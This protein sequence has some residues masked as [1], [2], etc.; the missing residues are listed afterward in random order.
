MKLAVTQEPEER[1]IFRWSVAAAL[2]L[3]LLVFIGLTLASQRE[4]D[5]KFKPLASMDF[6]PYDPE[7][8]EPGGGSEGEAPEIVPEAEPAFE[9]VPEEPE[10]LPEIIESVSEE[11]APAPPPPP[12]E[13]P[14]PK[15]KPKE[16]PRPAAAPAAGRTGD[17]PAASQGLAGGRGIG[18]GQGGAGGGT[19]QGT[20]NALQAYSSQIRRRLER[21]K[22]YP[23]AAQSKRITGVATISFTVH[24]NGSVS[25][26]R[27]VRSSGQNILDDEVLALL[28]RVA[29]LPPIPPEVTQNSVTLTVPISFSVR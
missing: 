16:K 8:G 24:R 21:N 3:H 15:P 25:G 5:D 2:A 26:A 23:P 10:E 9:E 22:K 1:G 13:K 14:K 12:K 6:V 11:A 20:K 7:G 18:P 4:P 17:A 27:L 28:R 19:G 29:P